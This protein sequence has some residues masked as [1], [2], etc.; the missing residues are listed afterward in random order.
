MV[1]SSALQLSFFVGHLSASSSWNE[2]I[3]SLYNICPSATQ[4]SCLP[5]ERIL[6]PSIPHILQC[7]FNVPPFILC[8]EPFATFLKSGL[9]IFLGLRHFLAV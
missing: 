7:D 9:I 8:C 2:D 6:A 5:N 1:C 4:F 3:I